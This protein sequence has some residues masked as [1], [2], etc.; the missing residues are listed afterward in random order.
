MS[1]IGI[2]S[3]KVWIP[4]YRLKRSTD[5]QLSTCLNMPAEN[6]RPIVFDDGN[7]EFFQEL[8]LKKGNENIQV[9][10]KYGG[11]LTAKVS[12]PG[13][14]AGS[15]YELLSPKR[16]TEA[17]E[18]IFDS[19]SEAGVIFSREDARNSRIDVSRNLALK[20]RVPDYF[21]FLEMI[22]RTEKYVF[23]S[24]I[25]MRNLSFCLNAY[26][27]NADA[28]EK[29][30]TIPKFYLDK[31]VMRIEERFLTGSKLRTDS[32][33]AGVDLRLVSTMT[34][35]ETFE[36]VQKLYLDYAGEMFRYDYKTLV[37]EK[38]NKIIE[39]IQEARRLGL[40]PI[41]VLAA[42]N[43]VFNLLS[44]D[45][46]ANVFYSTGRY[47]NRQRYQF[48]KVYG[49]ILERISESRPKTVGMF[50]YMYDELK[51]KAL[52]AAA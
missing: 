41:Q 43:G 49:R 11:G 45:E 30:E 42:T 40:R 8:K 37:S 29:K 36:K 33:K 7:V 52:K 48:K 46:L 25:Y 51:T 26:D 2:D 31:N 1:T 14:L 28:N 10:F 44:I 47:A 4:S 16:N 17:Y 34:N 32:K 3:L 18:F 19:L 27:K 13:V 5:V 15:N 12:V 23:G 50:N 21:W 6:K 24:S 35:G 9:N 20:E 38:K 22:P 39:Q